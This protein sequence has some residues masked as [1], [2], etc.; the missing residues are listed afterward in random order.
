MP[1]SNECI[2]VNNQHE[3][4]LHE[5]A[6]KAAANRTRLLLFQPYAERHLRKVSDAAVAGIPVFFVPGNFGEAATH[7]GLLHAFRYLD[8]TTRLERAALSKL[9]SRY[10]DKLYGA[11]LFIVSHFEELQSGPMALERFIKKSG[12]RLRP[13]QWPAVACYTPSKVRLPQA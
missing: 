10:D 7:V 12:G 1:K 8:E 6:T 11:N 13:G 5:F 4:R 3:A 2:V 9:K